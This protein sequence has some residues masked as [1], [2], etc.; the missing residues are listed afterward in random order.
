MEEGAA[1]LGVNGV[2]GRVLRRPVPRLRPLHAS[3]QPVRG[4]PITVTGAY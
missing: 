2:V 4:P 1:C 3:V